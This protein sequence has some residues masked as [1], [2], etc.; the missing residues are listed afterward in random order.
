M[1]EDGQFASLVK[2][3]QPTGEVVAVNRFLVELAGLESA[4]VGGLVLF[5]NGQHGLVRSISSDTVTVLNLD[6]ESIP[7]GTL[8]VLAQDI[9]GVK[10]GKDLLGRVVTPFGVPI[11]GKGQLK[12]DSEMPVFA[13]APGV[14]D[15]AVQKDQ[16]VTGVTIV[17]SLFPI[18]H[19]QRMAILG[20]SKAGKST[21]MRQLGI[22]QKETGAIMVYVLIA[23]RNFD[24]S[25]LVTALEDSGAIKRS[26]VVVA[27]VFDSLIQSYIAPYTACAM[28]EY[29]WKNGQDV[30]AVYDDLTSHAKVYREM[31]LLMRVNPGRDSYPGDMFYA[32]SSLLERAGKLASNGK[33]LTALPIVV[34]PNDDITSYLPTGIMSMTDGQLIFDLATFRDG[35]RPAVNAGLSVS[36]YGGRSQSDRA[37]KLSSQLFKKLADYRQA[38][39]FSHFGSDLAVES[40]ADLTLGKQLYEVFKQLPDEL[41]GLVEQQLMLEV[42][43]KTGGRSRVNVTSLKKDVAKLAAKAKSDDDYLKA[44]DSLLSSAVVPGAAK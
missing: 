27:S 14:I 40:Q 12:L 31:S 17:D 36:R 24:V 3:G 10:V 41:H 16:L 4:P 35:I 37:K 11:D 43:L 5:E 42:V 20:D 18:V 19:G 21:F 25:A 33:T 13:Q 8:A 38:L 7:I 34:T 28:A 22:N 26:I 9:F 44:L 23:K 32:H 39:E 2:K 6:G 30:I 15:R 1:F 29:F